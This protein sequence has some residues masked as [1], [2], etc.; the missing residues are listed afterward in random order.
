MVGED[1]GMKLG[2]R[3]PGPLTW[4]LRI[5]G[6]TV[7]L[8]VIA[9]VAAG[10][11]GFRL[12]QHVGACM[13][14][15]M[16]TRPASS[17][18]FT[19]QLITC[20]HRRSGPLERAVLY[21]QRK[22]IDALPNVPC[23]YVGVWTATR[24]PTAQM[25]AVE[26]RITLRDDSKFVAQPVRSPDP[27][28]ITGSWGVYQGS[29]LWFYDQGHVWPPDINPIRHSNDDAFT[30]REREGS[31]TSYTLIARAQSTDCRAEPGKT[32]TAT[33]AQAPLPQTAAPAAP[34]GPPK[35]RPV[36]GMS[37]AQRADYDRLVAGYAEA[38]R[39][40]IRATTCNHP[41]AG[42]RLQALIE[43]IG[44]RH[45]DQVPSVM[46]TAAEAKAMTPVS[47]EET[48][49]ALA[50]LR[51]P[52]IPESLLLRPGEPVD[53]VRFTGQAS[54][55]PYQLVA[56]TLGDQGPAEY[57]VVHREKVAFSSKLEFET[58]Q[59]LPTPTPVLVLA[60]RDNGRQCADGRPH[61]S[62]QAISLPSW[63]D[64][65]VSKL[66]KADCLAV[67]P[68]ADANGGSGLCAT[69][70][71]RDP[72]TQSVRLYRIEEHG[73]VGFIEERRGACPG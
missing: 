5:V 45:G 18:D 1:L 16:K 7:G 30:L 26:Y 55:G 28:V 64:A 42:A 34:A 57:R 19:K 50:S 59:L 41:E 23:R 68:Y 51:L 70:E 35:M 39:V 46:A 21:Y 61:V 15:M 44:R 9:G 32:L 20:A 67:S 10:N 54:T 60:T 37:Q 69:Q 73:Q 49:R 36:D 72:R 14:V 33:A 25:P 63:G 52:D 71:V 12:S 65:L 29:M 24:P 27:E 31:T 8:A 58:Q 56:R 43:E 13:D 66:D 38:M 3:V 17:L 6:W 22:A 2:S 53:R 40:V 4:T 62:W 47:C 48:A 11:G